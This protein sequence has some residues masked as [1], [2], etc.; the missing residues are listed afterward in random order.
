M[1]NAKRL[2]GRARKAEREGRTFDATSLW[3]Q[4]SVKAESVL[5]RHPRSRWADEARLLQGIARARLRDCEGALPLLE[6]V[7]VTSGNREFG[8][9]AALQVGSC[10][11]QLGDPLGASSAYARLTGSADPE[12]QSLA[13]YAHGR[14]LRLGGDPAGA[15]AELERSTDPRARGERAAALA[16]VGRIPEARA[17]ADQLLASED[18][19]APWDGLLAGLAH[20]A[21]E[22]A[23]TL[24]E[25]IVALDRLPASLRASVL[26]QHAAR[27]AETDPAAA[28][29]RFEQAL[30]LSGGTALEGEIRYHRATATLRR[31][32]TGADLLRLTMELTQ[33][34]QVPGSYGPRLTRLGEQLRRVDL[35]VDSA[36]PGTPRGDLRLFVAGELARDSLDAPRFAG[37]QF[38]RVAEGWPASP[39]APKAIMA[40]IALAPPDGDSL[41]AVLHDRYRDSPYVRFV[42]AGEGP[43][44]ELLEDSLRRFAASFR[45]EGGRRPAPRPTAPSQPTAAPRE[46][47]NR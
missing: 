15:L 45:P 10:R 34:D 35:T 12:R 2:A 27:L 11:V 25:Q 4:V 39:F 24:L 31:A 41:L 20:H 46:P 22:A 29:A 8:E 6:Q 9:R 44:L 17:A 40:A 3:G 23:D 33:L 21:P 43:G 42:E 5:V 30:A 1:Y 14:A 18:S 13:L 19:L 47:V 16:A 37:A 7:M 36:T 28:D 32:E 26:F 38:R